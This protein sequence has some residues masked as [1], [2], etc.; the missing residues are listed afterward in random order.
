MK[1]YDIAATSG[2]INGAGAA[3]T[4]TGRGLP[5]SEVRGRH[6]AERMAGAR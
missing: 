6:A 4:A 3:R 5:M 2:G 1:L